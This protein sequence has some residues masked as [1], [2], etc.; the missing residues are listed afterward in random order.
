MSRKY[1]VVLLTALALTACSDSPTPSNGSPVAS[2][3]SEAGLY[4]GLQLQTPLAR[5]VFT[6]TDDAGATYDFATA[7]AG[8]PTFLFFGYTSCPDICPTTMADV[9]VAVRDLPAEIAAEV[10]VVFVTTDPAEDTGPVLTEFLDH[11]DTDLPN[12]FVGLTGTQE[13]VDAAQ[14]AARVTVAMDMGRTHSAQLQLYGPD[15]LAR[16]IYVGGSSPD[17]MVHDLPLIMQG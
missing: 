6:L 7:T 1:V 10:Q 2:V 9:A 11:F 15:D 4:R 13:Q 8:K 5:P 16:V 12:G 3:S 17:D 14:R